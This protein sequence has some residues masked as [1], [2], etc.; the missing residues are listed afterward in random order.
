MLGRQLAVYWLDVAVIAVS[1]L[2]C[3]T[4]IAVVAYGRSKSPISM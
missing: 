4:S 3:W 1:S 2:M